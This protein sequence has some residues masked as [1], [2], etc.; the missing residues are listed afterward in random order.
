MTRVRAR[1]AAFFLGLESR[2]L[3]VVVFYS[4]PPP[5]AVPHEGDTRAH[6]YL[7]KRY[8]ENPSRELVPALRTV[9]AWI[10]AYWGVRRRK[11]KIEK[12]RS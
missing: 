11:G 9:H 3:S 4:L 7:F 1:H 12:P 2:N 5:S 6:D 8:T 10:I